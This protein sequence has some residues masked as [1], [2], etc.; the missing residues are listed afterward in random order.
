MPA[1]MD[2]TLKFVSIK[3]INGAAGAIS[4]RFTPNAAYDVD[5][6][7]GSTSTP[8]FAEWAA[9]YG[10]YRVVK[11]GY[12]CEFSNLELTNPVLCY[13]HLSNT[14]GGL[15]LSPVVIGNALSKYSLCAVQNGGK[16]TIRL[17]DVQTVATILGSDNVENDD[18]YRALTNGVPADLVWLNVGCSSMTGANLATGVS[19]FTVITMKIRFYDRKGNLLSYMAGPEV[20][21]DHLLERGEFLRDYEK[22]RIEWKKKRELEKELLA[23]RDKSEKSS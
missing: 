4:V 15:T 18:N 6:L 17:S 19:V 11:V 23:L 3:L 14:D 1:E 12:E 21:S 5:P 10:Y 16:S 20:M 7:L 2:V 22:N 9:L 13:T 8:G